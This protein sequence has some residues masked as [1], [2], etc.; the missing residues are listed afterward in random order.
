MKKEIANLK[1]R[2]T[3]IMGAAAELCGQLDH[4]KQP[5]VAM[6]TTQFEAAYKSLLILEGILMPASE[7]KKT[8]VKKK[9][10]K[11][12]WIKLT[13]DQYAAL[14]ET[15]GEAELTRCISYI[16]ERAQITANKSRWHD[17]NL[18]I[19]NCA[20]EKWGVKPW[21]TPAPKEPTKADKDAAEFEK[22]LITRFM[23]GGA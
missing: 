6:V 22:G 3:A 10:G 9:Y 23:E 11:Y 17:W 21:G 14:L 12:G 16:D 5:A 15:L 18:V 1:Q 7:L 13:D 4:D 8:P 20:R 19:Q 2:M